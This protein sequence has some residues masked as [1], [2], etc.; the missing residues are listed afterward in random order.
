MKRFTLH[1]IK[2]SLCKNET[3]IVP[4]K[5][6]PKSEKKKGGR[7]TYRDTREG[8]TVMIASTACVNFE[9]ETGGETQTCF[10]DHHPYDGDKVCIPYVH[11]KEIKEDGTIRHRFIGPGSFCDIYCLWTYLT[12]E[13]KK[14]ATLRDPRLE[15]AIQN[16]MIAFELM[17]PQNAILSTRP[18][19]TLLQTY[20]GPLTIENYRTA[21]YERRYCKTQ[22]VIFDSAAVIFLTK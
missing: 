22:E 4:A 15:T 21:T 6:V 16:T 18:S 19:W 7:I 14:I 11:K 8:Y 1:G 5:I 9:P 10:Q 2:A 20:G 12:E 13:G 17:Y 3:Q